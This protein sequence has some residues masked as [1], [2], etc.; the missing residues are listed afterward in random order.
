MSAHHCFAEMEYSEDHAEIAQLGAADHGR[1]PRRPAGRRDPHR[2][3]TDVDFGALTH[4]LI[5]II[6]RSSPASPC[7]TGITVIGLTPD[8]RRRWRVE[9]KDARR[10]R[11]SRSSAKFVFLGAGGGALTLLQKSGIPEAHGYGGFP[12]SGIWLRCDVDAIS[13]RHTPRST[14]KPPSRLAADV[15][16]APRHP[17]HRRQ[18]RRCCSGPMPASPRKF[19]KHGSLTDLFRSIE[20]EQHPADA[21]G[22]RATMMALTKYLIG[23]VLQSDASIS[24]R[25]LLDSSR[26][27]R[28]HDWTEAVAGQRVQIIKPEA[29]AQG[30]A[31]VRHR[32]GRPPTIARSSLCSAP[33]PAPPRRPSSR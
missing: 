3:G 2:H 8:G 14:A 1:P 18:A 32:T 5:A 16:A 21:R 30:R 23:Q 15:G 12:V 17:R 27:R 29:E 9:V 11:S 24:S 22:R 13:E 4:L 10:A 6:S 20:L 33:R 25:A 31:R 26:T 28:P 19:L 7:T